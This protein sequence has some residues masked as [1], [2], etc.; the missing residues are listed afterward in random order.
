MT[1]AVEI[2]KITYT[3]ISLDQMAAFHAAF[4][5]ALARVRREKL[6][7]EHPLLI[8]G[9][10]VRTE[11]ATAD[12]C[13][14]DHRVVLGT[15][16]HANGEHVQ[17]ALVA[18]RRAL[19]VWSVMPYPERVQILRRAARNF[20][21]NRFEIGAVLSMEAGKTRLES[22]GEVDEAADLI[23]TYCDQ[24]VEHDGYVMDLKTIDAGETNRSVL[25]PYGVFAVIAPFNFP[26]ALTT[27][28]IAGALTGGNTVVYKPSNDTPFT[29]H[30]V[31]QM[32]TSAGMPEG[33][34]NLLP[35][36]G[37]VV[38]EALVTDPDVDGVAF[39]G[40]KEVGFHIIEN[41]VLRYP[42]PCIAEMGGKNPVLVMESADLDKAVTGTGRAAFGY[43]GQKCS[44][45][46]RAYVHTAIYDEFVS[47]LREYTETLKVGDPTEA[48]TFMGPVINDAA[49]RT[50]IHASGT[51]RRDGR[52]VTGGSALT[53]GEFQYGYYVEPTIV[54]LPLDHE[55][56]REELFLPL[57]SVGRVESLE[58][59]LTLAN[60]SEFGL[61]AGIFTEDDE[62]KKLFLDQMQAGVLYVNR[63]GGATTGAWPGVQSFGGWKGS[64]ST[65]K[66]ALGP[67]YVAQFMHEQSQTVVTE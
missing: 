39:I 50:F 34:L 30:Y 20:R 24:L 27:G 53:D 66:S 25:K 51:A 36:A 23:D 43:C 65:G 40:S 62:E 60:E 59:A 58:Q 7:R 42:R 22:I 12:M 28:M 35:G 15:F 41:S 32:F 52:L 47:R 21:E 3:T 37:S 48:D 16:N 6:G 4:D 44:A 49:Y 1:T 10:E 31:Y 67:Y 2:P 26:V 61:T 8:G 14:H 57:L 19:T 9:R 46:S 5:Q 38:G 13:P 54:E 64:G 29:A 45:A 63:K 18:A 11:T 17:Q 33:A 55:F 56:F